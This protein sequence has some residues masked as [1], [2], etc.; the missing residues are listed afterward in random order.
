MNYLFKDL[1]SQQ[2]GGG[3]S[4]KQLEKGSREELGSRKP[5]SSVPGQ[6]PLNFPSRAS[7]QVG[8]GESSIFPQLYLSLVPE[9]PP[10]PPDVTDMAHPREGELA[11]PPPSVS[12]F[13]PGWNHPGPRNGGTARDEVRT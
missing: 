2:G 9:N 7:W 3:T 4:P 8:H 10:A 5:G 11:A 1:E 6:A 13:D 12:R